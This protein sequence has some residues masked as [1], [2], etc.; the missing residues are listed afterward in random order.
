MTNRIQ[1]T[2]FQRDNIS[3]CD[4]CGGLFKGDKLEKRKIYSKPLWI[5]MEIV[6]DGKLKGE[7]DL[8]VNCYD[9]RNRR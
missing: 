2:E 5:G 3:I 7:Y 1:P 6:R 9:R 4:D 8:C